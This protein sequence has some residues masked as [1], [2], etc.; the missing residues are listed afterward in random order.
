MGDVKRFL[1]AIV[2]PSE[3]YAERAESI[4]HS[5]LRYAN[6]YPAKEHFDLI[7]LSLFGRGC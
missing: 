3:E 5:E 4:N 6:A 1:T 7:T 2:C